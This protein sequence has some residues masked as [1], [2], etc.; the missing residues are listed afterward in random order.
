MEKSNK[1]IIPF[2]SCQLPR[3]DPRHNWATGYVKY[4]TDHFVNAGEETVIP[5]DNGDFIAAVVIDD[6]EANVNFLVYVDECARSTYISKWETDYEYAISNIPTSCVQICFSE[7]LSHPIIL[8]IQ[9]ILAKEDP[10]CN[11]SP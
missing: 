8:R 9:Y 10:N 11:C 3:D 7:P 4:W 6:P 5:P 2:T 1:K